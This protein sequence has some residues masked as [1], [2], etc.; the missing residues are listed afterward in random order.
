MIWE[1]AGGT[2][3]PQSGV[4]REIEGVEPGLES[5]E[6]RSRDRTGSAW[7]RVDSKGVGAEEA[8]DAGTTVLWKTW[9]N[10]S[11]RTVHLEDLNDTD[12]NECWRYVGRQAGLEVLWRT[13]IP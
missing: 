6:L 5:L 4:L 10:L 2:V 1:L 12:G 13:E 11:L 8:G 7:G 3:T 9:D